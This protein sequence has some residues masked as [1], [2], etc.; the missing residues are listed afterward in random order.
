MPKWSKQ[1]GDWAIASRREPCRNRLPDKIS[2]HRVIL[3]P[4]KSSFPKDEKNYIAQVLMWKGNMLRIFL[5]LLLIA[6]GGALT[7]PGPLHAGETPN[8]TSE[9]QVRIDVAGRQR[10]LSQRMVR[11]ACIAEM[12]VNRD[13][14][15]TLL[16][17]SKFL[18]DSTLK[19]LREGGGPDKFQPETD[20]ATLALIAEIEDVWDVFKHQITAAKKGKLEGYS[21]YAALSELSLRLL[22]T[23]NALV[24]NLDDRYSALAAQ[25]TPE[26]GRMI[27]IAGRQ[28]MLI[29]KAG[30]EACLAQMAG[31]LDEMTPQLEQLQKTIALFEQSAFGLAFS[32]RAL[33]L[34]APPSAEIENANFNHWQEWSNIV[35]LFESMDEHK[36]SELE[37]HELSS[38][39]EFFLSALN[40]TVQK[41]AQ[42]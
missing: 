41:Y 39:I 20:P 42:L 29:Q 32:S 2:R 24:Q 37:L 6:S 21:D 4:R 14:N 8:T 38:S 35:P 18:F 3:R 7:L 26:L 22:Q 1:F 31:T 34:P 13:Q 33:D 5:L 23:S 30:K 10:M 9:L 15:I 40:T 28:R 36:L 27:N 11:T 17:T 12:D 19:A 25:G 16:L